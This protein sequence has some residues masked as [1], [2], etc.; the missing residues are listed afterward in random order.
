MK[1]LIA[2]FGFEGYGRFWALNEIIAETSEACIDISKKI[3]RLDLA[4]E[5][6]L[7]GNGLDRFIA[8]LSDSEIDLINIADNIITIDMVNKYLHS[9]RGEKHWNWKGGI[10]PRNQTVRS[11]KHY[12]KWI[13]AIFIRDNYTCRSCN[14]SGGKLNAHHVK[15]FANHPELRLEISNGITLCVDCHRAWHNKHGNGR[16]RRN[17]KT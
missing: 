13:K 1:A 6:G 2:E 4:N 10:T 12:K 17:G 14:K 3:N 11:S 9:H 5:L 8:F 15:S 7:D 16:G